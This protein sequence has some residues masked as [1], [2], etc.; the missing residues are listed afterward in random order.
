MKTLS[1]KHP[2]RSS[3]ALP[4][5]DPGLS[6][7]PSILYSKR[8]IVRGKSTILS[9]APTM[10]V[11]HP[12]VARYSPDAFKCPPSPHLKVESVLF[13]TPPPHPHFRLTWLALP[14]ITPRYQLQTLNKMY[15]VKLQVLLGLLFMFQQAFAGVCGWYRH[16]VSFMDT[17]SG[18][19]KCKANSFNFTTI[20]SQAKFILQGTSTTAIVTK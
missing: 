14:A 17:S 13:H 9:R 4:C 19:N 15:V 16:A 12:S 18:L 10:P 20:S 5:S 1:A 2:V 3:A 6:L 7:L 8:F 11:A